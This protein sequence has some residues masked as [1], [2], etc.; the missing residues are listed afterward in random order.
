M[1]QQQI[2]ILLGKVTYKTAIDH[3]RELKDSFLRDYSSTAQISMTEAEQMFLQQ[4]NNEITNN[5]IGEQE[6]LMKSIL[7]E[8][9]VAI[10]DKISGSDQNK[11]KNLRSKLRSKK[12]RKAR[13][14]DQELQKGLNEIVNEQELYNIVMN[15]VR[16]SF[17][18]QGFDVT[19]VLD[20]VRSYRDRVILQA[21]SSQKYYI[22]AGKGFIREGLLNGVISNA[23]DYIDTWR[24]PVYHSAGPGT[25]ANNKKSI[26]DLYIDFFQD[27]EKS[28][29][30][31]D[32]LSIGGAG[33]GVQ[34]KSWLVPWEV[35]DQPT[36]WSRY[37]IGNREA[38]LS[39][40][41]AEKRGYATWVQ[42]VYFL[43]KHAIEALGSRQ[44]LWGT[45][46]SLIWTY[47]MIEWFRKMNYYL[48]FVYS[49]RNNALTKSVSW[50]PYTALKS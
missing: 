27:A 6:S 32:S 13:Q 48:A 34:S 50:Q 23:L 18:T 19:D 35:H 10:V 49:K 45:G 12:T 1:T 26:Y 9:Q 21:N 47:K 2:D 3:Y 31:T 22:R 41:L 24:T 30:V 17:S 7:D 46:T 40:L 36:T 42:G 15:K 8:V 20:Q 33:Y 44:V 43:E 16:T 4:I 14:A 29:V 5:P 25:G 28:H 39:Q 37:S 38:L 11:I